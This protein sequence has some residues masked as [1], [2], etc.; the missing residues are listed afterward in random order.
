MQSSRTFV[1]IQPP[2]IKCRRCRLPAIGELTSACR[3]GS[4]QSAPRNCCLV[5]RASAE[6]AAA[7]SAGLVIRRFHYS[8]DLLSAFVY[9][10]VTA[11]VDA[12]FGRSAN[13]SDLGGARP[14]VRRWRQDTWQSQS[15]GVTASHSSRESAVIGG[16]ISPGFRGFVYKYA[17]CFTGARKSFF[18]RLVLCHCPHQVCRTIGQMSTHAVKCSQPSAV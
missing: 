14:I 16:H 2:P 3:C 10:G 9:C 13:G 18:T 6:T 17:D 8:S 11:A 4:C 12:R 7:V 1:T 5:S 15:H